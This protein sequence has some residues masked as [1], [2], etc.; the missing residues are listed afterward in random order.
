MSDSDLVKILQD[1][2]WGELDMSKVKVLHG[3]VLVRFPPIPR[4]L[5]LSNGLVVPQGI[6]LEG[7]FWRIVTVVAIGEGYRTKK[8]VMVP[9]DIKVGDKL[10][11][12]KI[13]GDVVVEG[14][15][16]HPEYRVLSVYPVH[17]IEAVLDP[18]IDDM[19]WVDM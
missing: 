6:A 19:A 9:H 1:G 14:A 3:H 10:L 7:K 13:F 12:D 15:V 11:V 4:E 5:T 2:G 18:D 16:T 8:N 17:Q